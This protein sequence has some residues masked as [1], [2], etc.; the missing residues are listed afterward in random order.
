MTGILIQLIM[1]GIGSV[2]FGLIFNVNKRYLVVIFMLGM[3]C[4]GTWLFSESVIPDRVFVTALTAGLVLAIA[5][6]IISRLL[7][8]P[9]TTF[10]LTATIPVIPG[11]WLYRFML[12][13]VETRKEDALQY[14]M[15]ALIIALGIAVGMSIVWAVCDLI[16]KIK[17]HKIRSET[18]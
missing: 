4:W 14:G 9:S 18:L 1:A 15:Q 3:L 6:E 10:F 5:S 2:A 12:A 11:G 7:R 8:A 13:M 17:R 16:R